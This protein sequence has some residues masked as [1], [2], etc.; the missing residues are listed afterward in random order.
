M[1]ELYSELKFLHKSERQSP[2]KFM[3]QFFGGILHSYEEKCEL[4][5]RWR[6]KYVCKGRYFGPQT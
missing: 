3:P 5:W 1:E 2:Q 6:Q 4:C